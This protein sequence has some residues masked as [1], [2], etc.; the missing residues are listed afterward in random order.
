VLCGNAIFN[1]V[2]IIIIIIIVIVIVSI[3][4]LTTV[5]ANSP[6]CATQLHSRSVWTPDS[7]TAA[8]LQHTLSSRAVRSCPSALWQLF[9]CFPS[10]ICV[11]AR[12]SSFAADRGSK[13][14]SVTAS[15]RPWYCSCSWL[16]TYRQSLFLSLK[17]FDFNWVHFILTYLGLYYS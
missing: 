12:H 8:T 10:G 13:Q 3:Y 6:Q 16:Q 1:L 14:N 5:A 15:F 11:A 9:S 17:L 7:R 4:L 2:I